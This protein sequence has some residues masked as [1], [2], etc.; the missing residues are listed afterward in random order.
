MGREE[1]GGFRFEFQGRAGDCPRVTAGPKRSHLGVCPGPNIPLQLR[2][3]SR[4]CI[5]GSP[6]ESGLVSRGSKGTFGCSGR[7]GHRY[8]RWGWLHA[9]AATLPGGLRPLWGRSGAAPGHALQ[10]KTLAQEINVSATYQQEQG[11]HISPQRLC[12][13]MD[14]CSPPPPPPLPEHRSQGHEACPRKG[15]VQD[16]PHRAG[17]AWG[18]AGGK[19]LS[20]AHSL[21]ALRLFPH[22]NEDN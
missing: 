21:T 8:C 13:H 10:N 15:R 17:S 22:L 11:G 2:Q 3:G 20:Q 5:P 6:G 16:Q 19:T 14:L 1:G 18:R 7:G 9:S 4:G 12:A